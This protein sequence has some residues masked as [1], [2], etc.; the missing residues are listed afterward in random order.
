MGT[1][2]CSLQSLRSVMRPRPGG[3]RASDLGHLGRAGGRKRCC[4]AL[5]PATTAHSPYQL[6]MIE[7]SLYLSEPQFTHM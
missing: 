1:S 6:R 3:G 5:V 4:C 7:K 2:Q